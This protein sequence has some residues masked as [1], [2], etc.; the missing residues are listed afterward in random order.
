MPV[1]HQADD[2]VADHI[3]LALEDDAD[4]L[5]EAR[6]DVVHGVEG[7]LRL[8]GIR[9][10]RGNRSDRIVRVIE[11]QH[12]TADLNHILMFDLN[13]NDRRGVDEGAVDAAEILDEHPFRRRADRGMVTRNVGFRNDDVTVRLPADDHQLPVDDDL[14]TVSVAGL[15]RDGGEL[16][17]RGYVL[18][19]CHNSSIQLQGWSF[20]E[21]NPAGN[22]VS[23]FPVM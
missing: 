2:H 8:P 11:Y 20:P 13:L 15:Q 7:K 12:R 10:P 19:L 6:N 23:P 1:R 4:V 5:P 9:A 21:E 22:G 16:M 18:F 17:V 14:T 3:G